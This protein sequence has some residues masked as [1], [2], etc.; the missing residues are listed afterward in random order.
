LSTILLI[1]Q[2]EAA[3]G[4][5]ADGAD[6][7]AV[8][9]VDDAA[10]DSVW[11]SRRPMVRAGQEIRREKDPTGKIIRWESGLRAKAGEVACSTSED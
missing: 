8:F 10:R 4:V 9:V 6:P 2:V 5:L 11:A 3:V 7:P 1:V